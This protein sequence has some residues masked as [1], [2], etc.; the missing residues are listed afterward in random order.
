MET[1]EW[2]NKEK[3]E[4][5][6]KVSSF[7]KAFKYDLFQVQDNLACHLNGITD[8]LNLTLETSEKAL[9]V[10]EDIKEKTSDIISNVGKVTSVT[11]KI[12][13]TTQSYYDV[14]MSKQMPANKSSVDPKVLS[15]IECKDRQLLIDIYDKEGSCTLDKSLME[16]MDTANT[17][18]DNMSDGEK[19]EK[20]KVESVHKTKRNTILLTMNSREAANWVREMGNKEMFS[21][22]FL[23][24]AHI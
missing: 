24:G 22:A 12:A 19:P 1:A 2:E 21:N 9:K 7:H 17:A 15:D 5:Q 11:D 8:I 23:K 4:M 20:V 18:L 16:L 13:D 3:M 10:A 14:L 6:A